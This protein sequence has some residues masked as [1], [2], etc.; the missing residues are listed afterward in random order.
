MKLSKTTLQEVAITGGAVLLFFPILVMMSRYSFTLAL[1]SGYAFCFA[2]FGFTHKY[3]SK[4]F[5]SVAHR[6]SHLFIEATL[7][8]SMIVGGVLNANKVIPLHLLALVIFIAGTI[9]FIYFRIEERLFKIST[10]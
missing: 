6:T 3:F 9:G 8:E 1:L 10:N 2:L 5:S 4:P 7:A